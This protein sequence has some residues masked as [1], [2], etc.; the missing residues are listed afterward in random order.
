MNCTNSR[1]NKSCGMSL[2]AQYP[3][4]KKT[5]PAWLKRKKHLNISKLKRPSIRQ[6][7]REDLDAELD[8]V[9]LAREQRRTGPPSKMPSTVLLSR[10]WGKP[11]VNT[12][13]G[14][15]VE[16][17]KTFKNCMLE[18]KREAHRA[19]QKDSKAKMSKIP[20]RARSRQSSDKYRRHCSATKQ[21]R[22]KDTLTVPTHSAYMMPLKLSVDPSIQEQH[23]FSVLTAQPYSLTKMQS[24]TDGLAEH[25]NNVL[26]RP[27]S[28]NE[29]AVHCMP[30][31][32]INN[33][34]AEPKQTS[35]V[36]KQ[37]SVSQMAKRLVQTPFHLK[38]I[39]QEDQLW[40]RSSLSS[41]RLCGMRNSYP[42]KS[43][44]LLFS[45]SITEKETDSPVTTT[46]EFLSCNRRKT[47]FHQ[48][49]TGGRTSTRNSVWIER[50]SRNI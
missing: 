35:E 2:K 40:L 18:E 1:T 43:G 37:L 31:V 13:T 23:H 25:F 26:N 6:C 45:I 50:G 42:R 21:T 7:L 36:Q 32:V 16:M 28:I 44:T 14:L 46:G 48:G 20:S 12:R 47:S 9:T 38:S 33:S 17:T 49:P 24:L 10:T 19:P 8:Q 11:H 4:S 39:R 15:I 29:E 3:H 27:S 34:L 41:S 5:S 30:E 22:Y